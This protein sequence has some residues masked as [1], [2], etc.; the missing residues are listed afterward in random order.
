[1]RAS[2]KAELGRVLDELHGDPDSDRLIELFLSRVRLNRAKPGG[3]FRADVS[4]IG[5][6]TLLAAPD[7]KDY[8][9]EQQD[10]KTTVQYKGGQMALAR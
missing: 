9:I 7:P 4:V 8:R 10:G 5:L 3:A 1:L 6:N 2:L